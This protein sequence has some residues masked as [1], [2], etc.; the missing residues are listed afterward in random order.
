MKLSKQFTVFGSAIFCVVIFSLYLMLD[1]VQFD[2]PKAT[3]KG[4]GGLFPKGQLL[5]LHEKIDH[6]ERLLAENNEIIS[7]IRDSVINLSESVKDGRGSP[8]ATNVSKDSFADLFERSSLV[9]PIEADDCQFASKSFT[10]ASNLQMLD[11]YSIL[12]FDNPDGGVWKQGFDISY[13][14]HEWDNGPLQVFV[15]PHSHNDPGWLKTFDDYYRDQTQHILNNMVVKLQEDI[16]RRF[17]WTE[18]S[19]FSKWWDSIDSQKKDAVKRL[20]QLGQFEI[21]TGGWVMPDEASTHYFAMIDQLLEGH[22]WLERN[23]GVKPRAGWAIDPFGHTSTM[24]YILKKTG[25]SN[26]LI[27]R[28]HYSVKKY[29]ATQR[30]LEFF[31]R[32]NWDQNGSTDILCHMMPFYSYDVP[33]TCGPDPKICCQFDFKRL[34]GGRIHCPWRIPPVAIHDDN[35]QERAQLLLDQYRKKSKLFSTKVVLVPLGDDFRY[36]KSSEWDQQFLNYQK[37]FDYM[38]S[39]PELHVKAQ[40]G[41]L[42]DYFDALNKAAGSSMSPSPFPIVSGDFFT[43]ADRDDH[44]WS[45]YFTSRPFYKRLDRVLESHLRAAEILY[46][47][48]LV[49]VQKSNKMTIFPSSENYK[50]LVEARRNLGLF[51]H[52]DG[53]TGTS[54][55]WVV[56]DYGTRL[57]HSI[58]N[59]KRVIIDAA[60]FLILKDK[61]NYKHTSSTPFL[62]MDDNQDTQDALPKKTIIGLNSLPRFLVMYNPTDQDRTSVVTVYVN[63]Y[64]VRVQTASGQH[65]TSQVSAVWDTPTTVSKDAFQVSFLAQVPAL[66][67]GLYQL[68][69]AQDIKTVLADYTVC[70]NGREDVTVS[71]DSAFILNVL[72]S[73]TDDLIIEN[74][75]MKAWFSGTKGFIQK[76]KT[77]DDDKEHQINI[78]FMWYGTTSNRDKSGAYLFLPDGEA[79]PYFS[80]K[81][82]ILRITRG[83]IFSEIV[84]IYEHFTHSV[85]LNNVQGIDGLSM[86]V[87]NIV[88]ITRE[89]NREM[90]MRLVTDIN[91]QNQFYTDLNDF[92]IQPRQTL[93][94]LP[95]QANFYP[96]T[97]TAYIQDNGFRLTLHS[98]QSLGVASL[99]SGQLEIIMDRRLMQDDNRGLGQGL[100]DNK[101]TANLFRL[102]LERKI[103]VDA[104]ES[105]TVVNYQSLLSHITSS[106]LNHPIIPMPVNMNDDGIPPLSDFFSPL[107]S[108]MPCDMH[109]LNLRTIGGTEEGIPSDETALIIHRKGFDC[110]FSNKNTGLLCSTTRGKIPVFKLFKNV[111]IQSLIPSS[112][113]LMHTLPEPSNT[114]EIHLNPMEIS[115]FRI[116]LR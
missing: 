77:K 26:M 8:E 15:V 63:S 13:D 87:S 68:V 65:V 64:K 58:M 97:T 88:D 113:T 102:L 18:I 98:A 31:W 95:L 114:S 104:E 41:T 56:V 27:Q 22:Q 47:L 12:P 75:N 82:P 109:L 105:K 17:M 96:L 93:S 45:G 90:V 85:R 89:Q 115:T 52:H 4:G 5:I 84:C 54:K 38:N 81:P 107:T 14:E 72:K 55:E 29:F 116:R 34:P 19:Y 50:L 94:K 112:L 100:Q 66:G 71:T 48:A 10:K 53:I 61:E 24:A 35:I 92:Q 21:T 110:R 69:E 76:I 6:L 67:L 9:I 1:H 36:D 86:E 78:Q 46:S 59:L 70:L 74:S 60:H 16:R 51:Q 43:Y 91:S 49:G 2:H 23:L 30:K 73:S 79:K 11:V 33:H 3:R 57:F 32:Q 108:S 101:V 25:F 7:N 103:G 83:P 20:C 111:K 106:Y 40:F 80:S 99:K 42:S 62:Q 44:Y 37:L 28:V 39:H